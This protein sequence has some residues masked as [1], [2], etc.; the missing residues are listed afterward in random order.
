MFRTK[1]GGSALVNQ[2]STTVLVFTNREAKR[3]EGESVE[4][5]NML[6]FMFVLDEDSF[7]DP[8]DDSDS[9]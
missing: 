4:L 2:G 5:A 9:H 3:D 7:A 8:H 1:I 6:E